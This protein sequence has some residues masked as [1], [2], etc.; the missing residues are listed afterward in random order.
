MS[1][2]AQQVVFWPGIFKDLETA[3]ATCRDCCVRAPSQS[4]IHLQHRCHAQSIHS[5]VADYC[6]IKGKTWLVTADRFTGW[7]SVFYYSGAAS[8]KELIK[9]FR[10]IFTTFGVPQEITKDDG[11]QFSSHDLALFLEK[12]GVE[13]RKS[14][15]YN[16]HAIL[17]AETAVKSAKH[18]ITSNTKS[19][20]SPIWDRNTPVQD[21]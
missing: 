13:H 21:A 8:S 4:A 10:D 16:P 6:D 20:G 9:A 7:V 17:R 1:N 12:W 3:R 2:R 14:A 19:D 18:I 5:I 11:P 15:P